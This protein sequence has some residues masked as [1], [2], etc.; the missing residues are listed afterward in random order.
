MEFR[1][2]T[3]VDGRRVRRARRASLAGEQLTTQYR[4]EGVFFIAVR[5]YLL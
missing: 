2:I 3:S 5:L 1:V 4:G